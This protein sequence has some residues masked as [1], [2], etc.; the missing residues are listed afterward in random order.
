MNFKVS[1]NVFSMF[2]LYKRAWKLVISAYPCET[3]PVGVNM[4]VIPVLQMK[5]N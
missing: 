2:H 4:G 1:N 5:I 3:Q